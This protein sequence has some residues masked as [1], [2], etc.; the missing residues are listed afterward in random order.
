MMSQVSGPSPSPITARAD[1]FAAHGGTQAELDQMLRGHLAPDQH[2]KF[3]THL[4][5][6]HPTLAGTIGVNDRLREIRL[7][8]AATRDHFGTLHLRLGTF[9]THFPV[10]EVTA[11][12]ASWWG[13]TEEKQLEAALVVGPGRIGDKDPRAVRF[14]LSLQKP[15][16]LVMGAGK[17]TAKATLV[18]PEGKPPYVEDLT[19]LR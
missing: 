9:N 16:S 13:L 6:Q 18:V 10:D 8:K 4:A 17:T 7:V 3:L 15:I 14:D 1:N 2:E 11:A 5:E 19:Y 12:R